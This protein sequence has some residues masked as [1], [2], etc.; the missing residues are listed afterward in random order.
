[1]KLVSMIILLGKEQTDALRVTIRVLLLLFN[2][3]Y[4]SLD[5]HLFTSSA[6]FCLL[7]PLFTDIN[8]GWLPGW[9]SAQPIN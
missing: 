8:N 3:S 2:I 4:V 5:Q 7:H 6:Y 1:M 9:K